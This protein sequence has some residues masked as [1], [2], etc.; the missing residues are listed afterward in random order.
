MSKDGKLYPWRLPL[1]GRSST[2]PRLAS[3]FQL[4]PPSLRRSRVLA[5]NPVLAIST[6]TAIPIPA[7]VSL[8]LDT[9][10][11]LGCC[12]HP[13]RNGIGR[14]Q[15]VPKY[16]FC[17]SGSLVFTQNCH[18]YSMTLDIPK[19]LFL[20]PLIKNEFHLYNVER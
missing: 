8:T 7:R 19:L 9:A 10:Q 1:R 3:L 16:H 6:A 2:P 14:S 20:L 12:R 5:R 13:R 18:P 11:F 15:T 4:K 17:S